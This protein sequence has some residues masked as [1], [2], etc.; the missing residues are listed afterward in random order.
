MFG[1][2]PGPALFRNN[3]EVAWGMIASMYVG[4]IMLVLICLLGVSVFVWAVQKSIPFLTP[5][6]VAV[7]V[8]GSYAVNNWTRDVWLMVFFGIVAYVLSLLEFP[9][10]N[11]LLGLILGNQIEFNFIKSILLSDGDP[12]VFFQKPISATLIWVSILLVILPTIK[13]QFKKLTKK[14]QAS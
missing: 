4:N 2:Q 8:A 3:P 5:L 13:N 7:C 9:M 11:L 6:I 10:V 1:L 12:L 14:R